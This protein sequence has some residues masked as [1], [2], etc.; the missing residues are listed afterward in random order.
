MQLALDWKETLLDENSTIRDA[1]KCL[2]KSHRQIVLVVSKNMKLVGT[3]TDGDIR[4]GLIKGFSL[5]EGAKNVTNKKSFVC[6]EADISN[7]TRIEQFFD[8]YEINHIPVINKEGQ[9]KGLYIRNSKKTQ[10]EL[11]NKFVIMAGGR[12]ERL[13]PYTKNCPKPLLKINGKPILEHIIYNA[14]EFGFRKFIISVNYLG[15]MIKEY[16]GDGAKWNID[17]SY[18]EENNRMGTAGSLS[19]IDNSANEPVIVSNGDIWSNIDYVDFL[20]FHTDNSGSASMATRLYEWQNPFGV[21]ESKEHELLRFVEK[22][23]HSSQ[24]NAGIYI[25]NSDEFNHLKQDTYCDMPD[26]FRKIIDNKGKALVYPIHEHWQDI[27]RIEDF[28]KLQKEFG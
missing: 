23:I 9:I 27:G 25:I 8:Q 3:V 7:P 13:L 2:D 11:K 20:K 5:E 19:F 24:I 6:Q 1:I 22:P 15:E 21:V 10:I 12:G 16:F 18:I 28:Q 4:R 26:L 17:I 14:K